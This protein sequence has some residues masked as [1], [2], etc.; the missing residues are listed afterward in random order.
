MIHK[1]ISTVSQ[2]YGTSILKASYS[3]TLCLSYFFR[4]KFYFCID[5][6]RVYF[7]VTLIYRLEIL[8][9]HSVFKPCNSTPALLS[10]QAGLLAS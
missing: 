5:F 10:D 7:S 6:S 3:K 2:N 4:I 8:K 1:L 9:R